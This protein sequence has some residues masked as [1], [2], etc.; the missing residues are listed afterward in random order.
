MA[1]GRYSIE[2]LNSNEAKLGRI[3]RKVS[4]VVWVEF[5]DGFV[6]LDADNASHAK[7]LAENW[8][9]T[10]DGAISASIRRVKSDGSTRC[11][12][13]VSPDYGE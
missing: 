1:Q 10:V 8:L 2:V 12:D 5:A 13:V 3:A 7:K 6:E 9:A 11:K 4:V